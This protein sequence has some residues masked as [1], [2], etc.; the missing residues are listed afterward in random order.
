MAVAYAETACGGAA[1]DILRRGAAEAENAGARFSAAVTRATRDAL[2]DARVVLAIA[3]RIA[4]GLCSS[5]R[6]DSLVRLELE[7]P[8]IADFA[9][10]LT[11]SECAEDDYARAQRVCSL[12]R[13]GTMND[14]LMLY[15]KTDVV[16]LADVFE[17]FRDVCVSHYGLDP[18]HYYTLPGET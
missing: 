2:A 15:L 14:Y 16:L 11:G 6:F 1:F 12:A 9:S 8:S 5:I 10:K 3:A 4:R 13:C 18:A 7:V 17:S